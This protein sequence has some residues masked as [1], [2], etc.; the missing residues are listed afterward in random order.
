MSAAPGAPVTRASRL[1][2]HTTR[3]VAADVELVSHRLMLRA[4]MVRQ[5]ASGIYSWLPVGWR[6]VRKI[7]RIVREEMDAAGAVECFLPA[8][9]PSDLWV[10]SGRW[11]EYGPELL[12][13][14]DRHQ[15]EF[16]IGPTHEEVITDIVRAAVSSRRQLP[17]NLYQIQTK[18]R[19]EIRPRFGVMRAR[20]FIMKDAYSFDVDEDGM[21]ES[22]RMMRDAYR[23]I[24]D[25]IGLRYRI[26]EAESGAIGGEHSH[27]FNVLADSGEEVIAH[28]DDTGFAAN[29]ERVACAPPAPGRPAPSEEMRKVH[30]PG[31]RTIA[32]LDEFLG[33]IPPERSLKTMIVSG[34]A[35]A[36]A[37]LLQGNHTLNLY[38]A[39]RCPRIGAHPALVG[40]AQAKELIGADFGS[41]GPVGMPLPV[42]ADHA[43]ANAH[44]FV[45]GA[46]END[47]HHTGVNFGRDCPEPEFFDLRNAVEGDPTPDGRGRLSMCRGIEVGHI[48][49]LGDKYSRAMGAFVGRDDG[50]GPILMGCYG[51]GVTRIA[52]AAIEQGHDGR[53][54]VFPEAIAPFSAVVVPVNAARSPGVADAA[55]GLA[56][57]LAAAG[58]DVLLDDRDAR[59]GFMFA[60]AELI[61]IP[62]RFAIGARDLANGT[63]EYRARAS[64]SA[65][66]VPAGDVVPF[67]E[68][69]RA[70]K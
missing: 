46:N 67:L 62:H 19:D 30:T 58:L 10:E 8:V 47:Q 2:L 43:V 44:D 39:G 54:I 22:Y 18:F 36:V 64:E 41:L 69:R 51:I 4:G 59:P 11:S 23:R 53:G 21:R 27:E 70:G 50:G 5:Q 31:V 55:E 7:E 6:V 32:A 12:R 37:V 3:D 68:G 56:G 40:P 42:V 61:G 20:E 38:K 25:R 13:L 35:G 16:C 57:R 15:R 9:Q 60:E 48:F 14:R 65:E 33:G 45:C 49:Q 52:A 17:V 34:D 26:V 29:V 28:C 24:F 1:F 63:V 66:T